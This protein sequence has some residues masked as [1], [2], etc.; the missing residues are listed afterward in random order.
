[1]NVDQIIN[2]KIIDTFN[3]LGFDNKFAIVKVSDRPDLSDFQC[4]GA[5]ALAKPLGKNP[6]EIASAI[7]EVLNQDGSFEKI[8]IDGPGFINLSLKNEF[9]ASLVDETAQDDRMGIEKT[10]N[11]KKIVMDYGGPNVAKSMHVGH[12]R[13]GVIGE[14]A[15]RLMRFVG[16][17]VLG[18][19][20]LGDWGTPMGMI[21]AQI[22]DEGLDCFS[23]N[24][25]QITEVYKRA[26]IKCKEDDKARERARIITAQLQDGN[27]EYRKMWQ[28]LRDVSVDDVKKNF[29]ALDVSFDLW[30]GESDAQEDSCKIAEIAKEKGI[31]ELDDGAHIIR[32]EES[33]KPK[34]P[35]IIVKS[36]GGFTYHTTD[37]GTLLSRV[38]DLHADEVIYF[39][40]IRQLFHFEQV[41]EAADK[42][43]IADGIKL[44]HVGFGTVNGA[45]GK[46][47][48]TR[49]GGVMTLESLIN[50]S[51][52]KVAESMPE[53]SEEYSKE[54]IDNLINDVAIAAIK[55]QDLKS[56]AAS[57]YVFEI[58]EFAKFEG[59]T[60]PYIQY[61]I[62]RI[63]SILRKNDGG[64]GEVVITNKEERDLCLKILQANN[65]V[66]RAYNELEPSVIADYVYTLAQNFSSFYN[67]SSIAMAEN[68][69]IKTSRLTIAKLTRDIMTLM[70][71][72]LG[73]KSPEVMLKK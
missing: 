36:D 39:T 57:G 2:K 35:V 19:V 38:R 55:F 44:K 17:E 30:L 6:R 49:D 20:H 45:D 4:N 41:F 22:M 54:Y 21:I 60:G 73:I 43:G 32:L 29:E 28:H 31:L 61:A 70:L 50:L 47:F 18:D 25:E 42:L 46:P 33:N 5:L 9:I 68:Q 40:D 67:T 58:D 27:Q 53:P 37:L 63:N 56:N 62:A 12:L 72:L 64:F 48:K 15:K 11:P 66:I 51:K 3:K 71:D 10:S 16:D 24:V 13:S 14:S 1:M 69:E 34:P 23:L 7:V 59:K 52:E 8:S 26:N 65:A